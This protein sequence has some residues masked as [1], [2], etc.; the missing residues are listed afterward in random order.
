MADRMLFIGWGQPVRGRE[1]RGLEV[2]DEAVGFYGRCQQEGRI[3]SFDVALLAPSGTVDGYF[4]LRG[5]A[6][7]L[8]ALRED[9]TFQRIMIDAQ[10]IVDDL[11]V[12]DGYAN[13]GI[14]RQMELYRD[15]IAK[16]PQAH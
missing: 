4:A 11:C 12:V 10:L 15:A 8:A 3:E 6:E 5:S 13:A 1:E 9:E 2:F 16:V 7:Q 14:A